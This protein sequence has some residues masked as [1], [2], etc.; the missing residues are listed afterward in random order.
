MVRVRR[1][2]VQGNRALELALGG[3]PV[4]VVPEGDRGQGGMRLG[5]SIVQPEGLHG[6]PLRMG[7]RLVRRAKGV[8]AQNDVCVC[9]P[10]MSAGVVRIAGN[11]LVEEIDG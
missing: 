8:I 7:M 10:C 4:V 6:R 1:V 11:R 3:G 2:G 5:E 9:Q